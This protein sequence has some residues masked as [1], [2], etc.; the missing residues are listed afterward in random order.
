MGLLVTILLLLF[1]GMHIWAVNN[2][3]VMKVLAW[4]YAFAIVSGFIKGLNS[5]RHE[6]MESLALIVPCAVCF[7]RAKRPESNKWLEFFG[8]FFAILVSG[9]ILSIIDAQN[10]N[11]DMYAILT[12]IM[13][14]FSSLFFILCERK[15]NGKTIF[16]KFERKQSSPQQPIYQQPII[17]QQP[18]P[19][20]FATVTQ[21]VET[22]TRQ[23]P[24]LIGKDYYYEKLYDRLIRLCNPANFVDNYN[25]EKVDNANAIYSKLLN[26]N[27][28]DSTTLVELTKMAEAILDVNLLDEWD[29]NDLKSKL[30]PKNFVQPYD[31]EKVS[32][33]NELYSQLIQPDINLTKFMVIKAKAKPL[34]PTQEDE[35]SERDD[36]DVHNI[37]KSNDEQWE[38][39][40]LEYLHSGKLYFNN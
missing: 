32:L 1:Y 10:R 16:P 40:R 20:S 3:K 11:K 23:N 12:I 34:F 17:I 21:T 38:R 29:Y 39:E 35:Q 36:L 2:R 31:A 37:I 24:N 7:W 9:G 14:L 33:S 15:I 13:A 22:P 28:D 27:R 18:I 8:L 25:K 5:Y 30:N 26:T 19:M 6:D 4:L